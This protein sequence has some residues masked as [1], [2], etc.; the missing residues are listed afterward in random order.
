MGG[1]RIRN[2]MESPPARVVT[3]LAGITVL[4][5]TAAAWGWGGWPSSGMWVTF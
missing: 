4:V 3:I 1:K 2:F 5:A